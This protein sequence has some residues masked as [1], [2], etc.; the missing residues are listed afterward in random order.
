MMAGALLAISLA[1]HHFTAFA[2][3]ADFAWFVWARVFQMAAIPFLSLVITSYSSVG[4]PW[5][6]SGQA[7]ALINVAASRREHGYIRC[8]NLAGATGAVP[9]VASR[10]KHLPLVDQLTHTLKL[11]SAYFAQHG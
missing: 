7:S 2:P 9:S 4:L 1:L 5:G 6:K 3:D 8:A 10:R 11:A